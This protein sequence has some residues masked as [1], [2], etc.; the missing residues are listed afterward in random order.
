MSGLFTV[1]RAGGADVP[2]MF[3]IFNTNLDDYFAPDTL[4]WSM[5]Q[6]PAGQLVAVSLTGETVGALNSY[7]IEDGVVS[8]ALFAVDARFRGMG[9]GSALLDALR[10]ECAGAGIRRIQLE[11]RSTNS[12][13]IAFYARRGFR[14]L[15]DLPGL[16]SD[17][18]DG[19]RMVLDL[20]A[21]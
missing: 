15:C 13:A 7:I 5:M 14:K 6:W 4:E 21:F 18:G 9:A 10:F 11:A 8:L 2:A 17:G 20:G 3:R 12:S 19:I 16:Y 1:R